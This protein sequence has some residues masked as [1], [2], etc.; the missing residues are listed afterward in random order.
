MPSVASIAEVASLIGDPARTNML[1]ALK[2]EGVIS[3][4]ELSAVAGVAPST[5]SEHL[6]KLAGAGL[7]TMTARGRKRYYSLAEPDVADILEGLES[8]AAVLARHGP[9]LPRHDRDEALL[10]ARCCYDHLAGRVG[11]RLAVA[12][13]AKGYIGH[14]PD[15]PDL[16][17]DGAAWLASLGVDAGALR[18][19]PRRLLRLCPDWVERSVHVGGS[20]GAA[21]L[22]A[23]VARGWLRRV[24]G[25]RKV[26]VT[27][28]GRLELRARFGLDTAAP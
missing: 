23:M 18:A 13:I 22:R 11:V 19:E 1:F 14:A 21:M 16:T 9:V 27:P 4:G 15:G 10:H 5:A 28:K 2:D 24:R 25:A 20:V 26:L 7:V 6:A 12:L 8:V 3:A 17:E